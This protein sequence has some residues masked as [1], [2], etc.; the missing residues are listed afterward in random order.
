MKW[1]KRE[2][3]IKFGLRKI[4]VRKAFE[5]LDVKALK[6]LTKT[7]N[8][9]LWTFWHLKSFK[10]KALNILKAQNLV[11][12]FEMKVLFEP[13]KLKGYKTFYKYLNLKYQFKSFEHCD[14]WK[15]LNLLKTQ[16]LWIFQ[17]SK[18]FETS[19]RLKAFNV[20]TVKKLQ[21]EIEISK[22]FSR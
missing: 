7:L 19:G 15:S 9:K 14:R 8:K 17:Q 16:K 1:E 13:S 6:N 21:N 20:L 22:A 10:S 11:E 5:L 18:S 12:T 2:A 3:L 4:N